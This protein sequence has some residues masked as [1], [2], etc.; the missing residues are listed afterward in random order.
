MYQ[1]FKD[2]LLRPRNIADYIKEPKKKTII[3]TVI[4]LIVYVVPFLLIAL[5][6]NSAATSLSTSVSDD[7][8]NADQINYQISDGKLVSI[9]GDNKPQYIKTEIIIEQAYKLNALYVFDLT[10]EAYKDILEVDASSYLVLL[11][12]E[13]EFRIE[14]ITVTKEGNSNGPSM[15]IDFG[16]TGNSEKD[17]R[18]VKYTYEELEITNIDFSSNKDVNKVDFKNEVATIVHSIYSKLKLKLLPIIIVCVLAL[19]IGSYFIS[20]LFITLLF[21]L[22][23]R[24][25]QVDFGIVFKSTLLCSTPYVICSILALL[26]NITFL[27]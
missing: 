14:K 10:G 5:L 24:Y 15:E 8:I 19:A 2:C 26:T 21:K 1:R 16:L 25:L 7:F 9:T 23:Y 11:F 20:V 3:Y 12:T 4:L 22:L 17:Y 6:S 18:L 27:E 13:N